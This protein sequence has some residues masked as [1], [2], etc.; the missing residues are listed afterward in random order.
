M[1][2]LC[3]S[4][5]FDVA[6]VEVSEDA[7]ELSEADVGYARVASDEQHILIVRSRRIAREIGRAG[8]N[9]RFIG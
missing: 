2:D 4:A 9:Q 8:A 3:V 1:C 7:V 6:G 5:P